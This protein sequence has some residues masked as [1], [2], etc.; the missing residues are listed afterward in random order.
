[1]VGAAAAY[2]KDDSYGEYI[3]DWAWAEAAERARLRYYP[4]LVLAVPFTPATGPRLLHH[5]A[6]DPR[7]IRAA[8]IEAVVALERESRA[9]SSHFLFCLDDEA[10]ALE[11][12]GF[13]RRATHQ[14]HWRNPDYPDF[15]GFLAALR[16]EPRKQIKKERRKVA[17]AGVEIEALEGDAIGDR[18]W[19][20]W[21][22]SI[23][24]PETGS[25]VGLI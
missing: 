25:G 3:F 24:T 17:E 7:A 13:I 9:S 23:A 10:A 8:L 1:L 16:A 19:S 4:K 12:A 21:S 14:Y 2:L 15:D 20:C 22:D 18:G 5:P 6:E 11:E